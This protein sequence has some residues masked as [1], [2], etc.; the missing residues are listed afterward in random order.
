MVKEL[1]SI[2]VESV[3]LYMNI[4]S[5]VSIIGLAVWFASWKTE[6]DLF[7]KSEKV[8]PST[9]SSMQTDISY[10]KEDMKFVKTTLQQLVEKKG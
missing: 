8:S 5:I 3:K 9:V 6:L 4:G 10:I 7:M 1:Q 2:D